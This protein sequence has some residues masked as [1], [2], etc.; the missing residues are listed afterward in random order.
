MVD[1][2]QFE[3]VYEWDAFRITF[4][5]VFND[6]PVVYAISIG[7]DLYIDGAD[8]LFIATRYHLKMLLVKAHP[9]HL[10]QEAFNKQKLFSVY[11]LEQIDFYGRYDRV[12]ARYIEKLNPSLNNANNKVS[13]ERSKWSKEDCALC[14][15]VCFDDN[16]KEHLNQIQDEQGVA[17]QEIVKASVVNFLLKYQYYKSSLLCE[18][19]LMAVQAL[20]MKE[21]V[22]ELFKNNP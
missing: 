14:V 18:E 20:M 2:K 15:Q 8:D 16:M 9:N 21:S 3:K 13:I 10:M 6:C 5:R 4:A 19:G 22:E 12:L 7:E 1:L 17:I 11:V